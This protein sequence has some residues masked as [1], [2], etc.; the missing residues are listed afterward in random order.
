MSQ[1]QRLQDKWEQAN[2][3]FDRARMP[4]RKLYWCRTARAIANSKVTPQVRAEI[5]VMRARMEFDP[6]F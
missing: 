3:N 4:R 2:R 5:E 6:A 1:H